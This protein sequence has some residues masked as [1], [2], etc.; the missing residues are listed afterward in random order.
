MAAGTSLASIKKHF[1]RLSDPRVVGRSKHLLIDIIALA[2]CGVIADCDDWGDL[3]LFAR[4]RETW[5]RRF[6]RLPDGI[7]SVSTF[8]RVFA[9]LDPQAFGS[10]CVE[11]LRAVSGLVGVTQVAID[12]KSLRGSATSTLRPLHVVSAW[13]TDARLCLGQRAVDGK[14]NEITA[15]PPLLDLLDLRGSLVTLDAMGC[16][17]TIAAKI[18][19]RGGDFLLAV[20]SNQERLL[21]DVQHTLE[22]ALDGDYVK[23]QVTTI[24][25]RE[26]GHGRQEERSYTVVSNLEDIRDRE[27]WPKL[28]AVVM[29]CRTRVVKG[30][31]S[32]EC[33]YYI[34]SRRMGARRYAEALRG[35]WGIEN[36]LHWQL[37]VSFREDESTIEDP[38]AAENFSTMRKLALNLLRRHPE[39]LSVARKRKKA[40]LDLEFLAAILTSAGKEGKL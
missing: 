1:R 34:S 2:L 17:K 5:F 31:E 12:G 40:A 23:G 15:I 7:P 33:H 4:E 20:K 6:L 9:A 37:D 30:E 19:D 10:C 13:A 28:K 24:T 14:S 11:W 8:R 21:A 25:T 39:K 3:V 38:N 36:D 27:L 32:T 26:E 29:C 16:Q 18:I 22:K 35:H